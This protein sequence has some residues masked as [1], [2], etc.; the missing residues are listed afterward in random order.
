MLDVA[1]LR[2]ELAVERG[3]HGND[4]LR[5]RSELASHQESLKFV[6]EEKSNV[7]NELNQY[8]TELDAKRA[9]NAALSEKLE[10]A[11]LT[12]VKAQDGH[13]ESQAVS[14]LEAEA[15]RLRDQLK[16]AK[17]TSDERGHEAGELRS[18]LAASETE[19][20]ALADKLRDAEARLELTELNLRQVRSAAERGPLQE[21]H[22]ESSQKRAAEKEAEKL[23]EE[24]RA[25]KEREA[26]LVAY[27]QQASQD[28]EQ[29]IQQ[30]TAYAKQ[31][32]SQ[33]SQR[34]TGVST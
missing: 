2:D 3:Q 28:R 12:A 27:I 11:E 10:R 20:R 14:A 26:E 23:R 16:E 34:P 1:A 19:A 15:A 18:R 25:L 5:L 31:L 29:I 21:P 22:G 7:E 32:T 17:V 24:N 33:V 30:Y 6:V 8:R 13:N 4:L 9:E